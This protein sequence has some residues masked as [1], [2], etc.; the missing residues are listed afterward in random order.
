M[1]GAYLPMQHPGWIAA[2]L[3]APCAGPMLAGLI[4]A[5]HEAFTGRS[6]EGLL[7]ILIAYLMIG[8][9]WSYTLS[10]FLGLPLLWVWN[11]YVLA[12]AWMFAA[13]CAITAFAFGLLFSGLG[14]GLLYAGV[15]VANAGAFIFLTRERNEP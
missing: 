1:N 7:T 13:A 11:Q 3:V 2:C 12:P 8:G 9:L 5:L 14:V 15:A 10:A 4:A 6:G